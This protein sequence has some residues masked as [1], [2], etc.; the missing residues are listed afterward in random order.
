MAVR[1]EYVNECVGCP[2]GCRGCGLKHVLRTVY[3]CD[4]C[5]T[6]DS[7]LYQFEDGI[8]CR[9]CAEKQLKEMA[10]ELSFSELCDIFDVTE[11]TE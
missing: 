7:E 11:F 10:A 5:S 2:D 6:E 3:S 8:F 1:E 9:Q 4:D